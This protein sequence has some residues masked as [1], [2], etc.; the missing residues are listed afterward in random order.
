MTEKY[1]YY[2][3]FLFS[4]K[5]VVLKFINNFEDA[6][7]CLARQSYQVRAQAASILTARSSP[8]STRAVES[9]RQCIV[10]GVAICG[11]ATPGKQH[12]AFVRAHQ[13]PRFL[14]ST[15]RLR[16]MQRD[17]LFG[18]RPPRWSARA[19]VDGMRWR[20]AVGE[21]ATAAALHS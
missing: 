19:A 15:S 5:N 13:L 11:A 3:Y 10:R 4:I 14:C 20:C 9:V 16:A 1:S 8:T 6:A 7:L 21:R 2:Y 12:A 18:E 17:R